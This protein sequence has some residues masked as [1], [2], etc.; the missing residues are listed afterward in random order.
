[1]LPA[2][3]DDAVHL[4]NGAEPFTLFAGNDHGVFRAA[5]ETSPAGTV[6]CDGASIIRFCNRRAEAMFGYAPGALIGCSVDRL[7]PDHG[8]NAGDFD[9]SCFPAQLEGSRAGSQVVRGRRRDGADVHL[10]MAL[11]PI[12]RNGRRLVIVSVIEAAQPSQPQEVA[13]AID[14]TQRPRV[15][16]IEDRA[17]LRRPANPI[18]PG[19][20]VAESAAA[21][22]ALMQIA[23]VAPTNATVLLT[24]ETGSGK[25]V[26]AQAIHDKNSRHRRPMVRVNCGAIPAGLLESELFGHERGAFTG[27]LAQQIGR[28]EQAHGST[29]F[30][31]EIG[32][33]PL[34]GQV[35]LLRVLQSKEVERLGGNRSVKVDVRIIAATNRDLERAVESREFRA[36]LYY[37][38]NIFPVHVPALRE[39]TRGHSGAGLVVRGRNRRRVRQ[40]DRLDLQGVHGDAAT[41]LLAG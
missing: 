21:R 27:A 17:A 37:R 10:E 29:I 24:G 4:S 25:E 12:S 34:D 23:H 9:T 2:T 32:E 30:L 8:A 15:A 26:F 6:V 19:Q 38:L 11:T 39:R 7:I 20:V 28:F 31:D 3:R 18:A 36:D 5:I 14:A 1:M 35:K 13:S 22:Q 33:L 41:L 40:E 16:W